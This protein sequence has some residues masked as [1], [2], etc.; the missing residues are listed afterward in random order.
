MFFFSE[1]V[2]DGSG[3]WLGSMH[4]VPNDLMKHIHDLERMFTIDTTKL[5]E[6]VSVFQEELVKGRHLSS[7]GGMG[8]V[9]S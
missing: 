2:V 4:D 7:V 9:V 8:G 3:R 1:R 6:V 5:H